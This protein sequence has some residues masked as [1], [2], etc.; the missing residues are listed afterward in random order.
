MWGIFSGMLWGL[1]TV[2]L[3]IALATSAFGHLTGSPLV[4]AALHDSLCALLMLIVM[5]GSGQLGDTRRGWATS[6]G[7]AV[8]AAALLGGPIGMFGYA[9]A[10]ENPVQATRPFCPRSTRPLAH[11]WPQDY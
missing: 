5:A 11:S 6:H 4:T 10:I 9:L 8:S 2:I 1:D 7:K 3:S